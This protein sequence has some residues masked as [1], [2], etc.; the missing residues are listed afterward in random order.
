MAFT[1]HINFSLECGSE[2]PLGVF[3][4]CA[5]A[6][7]CAHTCTSAPMSVPICMSPINLLLALYMSVC[8]YGVYLHDSSTPEGM[9][10]HTETVVIKTCQSYGR[11]VRKNVSEADR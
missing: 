2:C 7:V 4:G 11:D 3:T 5:C 10:M 9:S 8:V 6:C 1:F